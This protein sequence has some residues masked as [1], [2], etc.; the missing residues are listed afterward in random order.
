MDLFEAFPSLRQRRDPALQGRSLRL[1]SLAGIAYD[2][3]NYYFELSEPRY[4]VQEEDEAPTVG[5]GSVK[6]RPGPATAPLSTLLQHVR[7]RWRAAPVFLPGNQTYLLEGERCV[8]LEGGDWMQ[9]TTPNFLILTPPRLGGAETP[10]A[11]AQAV[12]FLRLP[13][14]PRPTHSWGIV[15]V[16]RAALARFLERE[17]WMLVRLLAQPWADVTHA[18]AVPPRA[19]LRPVLALRGLRRLWE[20]GLFPVTPEP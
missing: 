15:R 10:D 5:V 13:R 16:E 11:L 9:P 3:A 14:P 8:V 18:D 7:E 1:L 6:T 19:Q 12:Y 20:A 17:R 4:W 2:E